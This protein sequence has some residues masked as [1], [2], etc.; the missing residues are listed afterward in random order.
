MADSFL[1]SSLSSGHVCPAL[2]PLPRPISLTSEKPSGL[3]PSVKRCI[4]TYAF[5]VLTQHNFINLKPYA[6]LGKLST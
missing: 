6:L 4:P 1:R 5:Y 2:G 3:D